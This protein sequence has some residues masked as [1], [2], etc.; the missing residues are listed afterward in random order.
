[1]PGKTY[2]RAC[3]D[4][5]NLRR[6]KRRERLSMEGRCINCM[7]DMDEFSLTYGIRTCDR[8]REERKRMNMGGYVNLRKIGFPMFSELNTIQKSEKQT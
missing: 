3:R 2:C 8:C 1:M 6:K 4:R 7:K 5:N